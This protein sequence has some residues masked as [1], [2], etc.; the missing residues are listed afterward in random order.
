M[1]F[2]ATPLTEPVDRAV[3]RAYV[4]ELKAT[5][6]MP[7]TSVASV[8]FGSVVGVIFLVMFG[9]TLVGFG[10]TVLR[11]PHARADGM[12]LLLAPVGILVIATLVVGLIV[13]GFISGRFGS[14]V[15]RPYRL[16]RFAKANGMTWYPEA[17]NPPLPGLIFQTGRDRLAT[18]IVRGT[19]PRLVEFANYRY[20]TGSGKHETTH[21]WGFVAVRLNTP[22][23]HI[24]LDATS[25]NSLFGSN[26]PLTFRGDQ[27][28]S[29]EG[30][31]DRHFA[32]YCPDGYEADAL[33]LFTP[34][35]MARFIDN[36]AALDVEIVDDWL[37]L[38]SRRGLSTLDPA[39]W[40]WLFS[41]VRAILDKMAQWERWRDDR[42][43][44]TS[45][46]AAVVGGPHTAL[47][48]AA[49]TDSLRPPPGVAAPGRRLQHGTPWRIIAVGGV[50][51]AVMF[52]TQSGLFSALLGQFFR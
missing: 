52:F 37:F 24:V 9:G 48:F 31:F 10:N 18:D 13:W 12:I 50:V 33:Y 51:V 32:L 29:L 39:M 22:L 42:L 45:A 30:D 3:A 44:T 25:N 14:G 4:R 6:R 40:E 1:G 47:P 23:P 43:D 19:Q 5:G 15:T 46:A 28:L 16:D 8:V 36:A 26:L 21:S 27:R 7:K 35:I 2:D 49:S 17:K 20:K 11:M 41:V 38:Y 34:D